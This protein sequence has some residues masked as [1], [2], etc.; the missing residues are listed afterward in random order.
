MRCTVDVLNCVELYDFWLDHPIDGDIKPATTCCD[1]KRTFHRKRVTAAM[2]SL[3]AAHAQE[4][5]NMKLTAAHE[6]EDLDMKLIEAV[7]AICAIIPGGVLPI[8]DIPCRVPH[9]RRMLKDRKIKKFIDTRPD[10]FEVVD[11]GQKE[12]IG[13][14]ALRVAPFEEEGAGPERREFVE[15]FGLGVPEAV[16]KLEQRIVEAVTAAIDE[17]GPQK[18]PF[19]VRRTKVM[20]RIVSLNKLKKSPP[21][22]EDWIPRASKVMLCI[23]QRTS[24]T[25]F[26]VEK[27]NMDLMEQVVDLADEP[28]TSQCSGSASTEDRDSKL[29]ECV[30]HQA[31]AHALMN[32]LCHAFD[33]QALLTL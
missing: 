9:L 18:V 6:Q 21:S 10:M 23:L 20:R 30:L 19:L 29:A 14:R 17:S 11:M 4:D 32:R 31:S 8:S 24:P 15:R 26:I 12:C 28:A 13:V 7:E 1:V 22:D 27:E 16:M 3:A 5:L 33:E 2:S 25:K